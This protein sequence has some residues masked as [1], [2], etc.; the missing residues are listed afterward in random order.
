[1]SGNNLIDVPWVTLEV[2]LLWTAFC[3]CGERVV[4]CKTR[5]VVAVAVS[6]FLSAETE[7]LVLLVITFC[8]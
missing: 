3:T 6:E 7:D 2:V 4:R 5:S 1:M 8:I